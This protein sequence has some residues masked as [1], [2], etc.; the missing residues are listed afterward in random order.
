MTP[1]TFTEKEDYEKGF[2][3]VYDR[4]IAPYLQELEEK[5]QHIEKRRKGWI[6]L[7]L[8]VAAY[9]A[10]QA[11]YLTPM[12]SIFPIF[13]GGGFAFLLHISRFDK[14]KGELT[15]FIRPIICGFFKDMTYSDLHQG[16]DFS[17]NRLR[18]LHIVP[19]ADRSHF[20]PSISGKW[21]DTA[22]RMTKATFVN[23][24]RDRDGDRK[25]T[26]VFSGILLEVECPVDMPKIVFLPDFGKTLNAVFGWATRNNRPPHQLHFPD[27]E[28]EKVFEVYTD[29]PERAKANLS[30]DFGRI[31]LEFAGD[32]QRSSKKHIAAA[33]EGKRF[34]LAIDLPHAFMSFDISSE[35]LSSCNDRIHQAMAD[36]MI[37]R[38]IIDRLVE[39][40]DVVK[41]VG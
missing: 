27:E 31:L 3:E 9:L 1:F 4:E 6:L 12:L 14:L 28:V 20:G 32:Y 35:P 17:V 2:S 39:G 30:P 5:R 19:E 16:E 40:E 13:F 15:Q 22:Y 8:L 25:S 24:T 23:Q 36:L 21:R 11:F 7:L 34:Y 29:D 26:V 18:A 38:K 10:W 37:P 41:E 33:F